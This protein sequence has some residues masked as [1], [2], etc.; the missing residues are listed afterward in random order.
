MK[1]SHIILFFL[2]AITSRESIAAVDSISVTVDTLCEGWRVCITDE[3]VNGGLRSISIVD[4]NNNVFL[5]S[6]TDSSHNGSIVIHNAPKSYCFTLYRRAMYLPGKVSFVVENMRGELTTKEFLGGYDFTFSSAQGAVHDF[7]FGTHEYYSST[8]RQFVISKYKGNQKPVTIQEISVSGHSGC[9]VLEPFASLLPMQLIE[10]TPITL[11]ITYRVHAPQL[12]TDTLII[13]TDC[14]TNRIVLRGYCWAPVITATDI[15]FGEIF[16]NEKFCNIFFFSNTGKSA[17]NVNKINLLYDPDSTFIYQT[18]L[19]Y[20]VNTGGNMT[21]GD[22]ICYIPRKPSD[23][24]SVVLR[25]VTDID[26]GILKYMKDSTVV[27]G[28]AIYPK[29]LWEKKRLRFSA[30]SMEK[31]FQ[32]ITFFNHAPAGTFVKRF[33]ITGKDSTEFSIFNSLTPLS[34]VTMT[35]NEKDWFDIT[36]IPDMTKPLPDRYA[37]RYATLVAELNDSNITMELVGTFNPLHVRSELLLDDFSFS[38]NPVYGQDATLSFTLAEPKQLIISIYDMLGREVMAIPSRY[39]SIGP[40]N[41]S[42]AT[43]KLGDGSYI[44]RVTDGVLTRSISFRVVR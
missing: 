3:K 9:F 5:D 32:T 1:P 18:S 4:L 44:V 41:Y 16:V 38:P 43:S 10:T 31:T 19:F 6:Q 11:D 21:L 12:T 22:Q 20:P 8:S 42:I 14:G 40:Q 35:R 37:D 36:F 25:Y 26:T 24:D 27:R 39:F 17:F 28:K 15:D 23:G 34:N 29:V 7:D 2:L 33:Y 13:R 30:D